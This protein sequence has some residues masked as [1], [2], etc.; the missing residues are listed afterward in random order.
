M[1]K[2]LSTKLLAIFMAVLML[3]TAV[4]FSALAYETGG[5]ISALTN[6]ISTYEKALASGTV[7]KNMADT[8]DA[9]VNAKK[10]YDSY[11]YGGNAVTAATAN[12]YGTAL[13]EKMQV[14]AKPNVVVDENEVASANDI[15]ANWTVKL[16]NSNSTDDAAIRNYSNKV[17]WASTYKIPQKDGLTLDSTVN[18]S[19]TESQSLFYVQY[20]PTVLL[21]DGEGN[22]PQFPVIGAAKRGYYGLAGA[23][24]TFQ[25]VFCTTSGFAMNGS[26]KGGNKVVNDMHFSS[27]ISG[28]SYIDGTNTRNGNKWTVGNNDYTDQYAFATSI[29]Y[30]GSEPYSTSLNLDFTFLSNNRTASAALVPSANKDGSGTGTKT[31]SPIYFV[32]YAPVKNIIDNVIP[33]YAFMKNIAAYTEDTAHVKEVMNWIEN[34]VYKF[35]PSYDSSVDARN[36]GVNTADVVSGIGT[37]ISN[38]ATSNYANTNWVNDYVGDNKDPNGYNSFKTSITNAETMVAAGNTLYTSSSWGKLTDALDKVHA[39]FADIDKLYTSFGDLKS[40]L[41]TAMKEIAD[42]GTL[43]KKADYTDYLKG[44]ANIQTTIASGKYTEASLNL[45]AEAINDATSSFYAK[46][47]DNVGESQHDDMMDQIETFKSILKEVDLSAFDS[48]A[49]QLKLSVDN[50]DKYDTVELEK[51]LNNLK[52]TIQ[53]TAEIYIA[54]TPCMGYTQLAIDTAVAKIETQLNLSQWP[55]TVTIDG[56]EQGTNFHYGQTVKIDPEKAY[57]VKVT[58]GE[59]DREI[60]HYVSNTETLEVRGNMT[61]ISKDAAADKNTATFVTEGGIL[62][63]VVVGDTNG[64]VYFANANIRTP[65]CSKVSKY[66]VNGEE[67]NNDVVNVSEGSVTV[68]VCFEPVDASK[69]TITCNGDFYTSAAYNEYVSITVD[70]AAGFINN[71]TGE[72]LWV[73]DTYSFYACES[74]DIAPVDNVT[75]KGINT[76]VVNNPT[77][78][79]DERKIFVGSYTNAENVTVKSQGFLIDIANTSG[80]LTLADV[81]NGEVYNFSG[82][83]ADEETHQFAFRISGVPS[84]YRY[85]A[86][87]TYETTE[88][89]DGVEVP[90]TK[91]VYSTIHTVTGA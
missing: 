50:T 12:V 18:I 28:N 10:A 91:T 63:D 88:I 75:A 5:D 37:E 29:V 22:A 20:G 65:V 13:A 41:D 62:L 42:G 39:H 17:L 81:K 74:I 36:Y 32:N 90:V 60:T 15:A 87:V 35:N 86:Y 23:T 57:V 16:S 55:Y 89:I 85:C 7:Y 67:F 79:Y 82:V 51:L 8:Y 61:V 45:L 80:T 26:W 53:A 1:K 25:A 49:D 2:K 30:N 38:I 83:S 43:E 78:T 19:G 34:T 64:N 69:Y 72:L 52:N 24:N 54:G 11:M 46:D 58:A 71:T 31:D 44:I 27:V 21:Y 40:N 6:A 70:G 14:F 73:G 56:E 77:T 68:V 48:A 59:T 76:Y 4:P 47:R 9:Y 84:S 3:V 66:L 33:N